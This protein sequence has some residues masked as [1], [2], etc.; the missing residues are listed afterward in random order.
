MIKS[1]ELYFGICVD[2]SICNNQLGSCRICIDRSSRNNQLGSSC[3]NELVV[4]DADLDKEAV[5]VDKANGLDETDDSNVANS[6]N[7]ANKANEERRRLAAAL[8]GLA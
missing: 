5:E 3:N 4:I 6:T 2:R 7:F 1:S 8:E